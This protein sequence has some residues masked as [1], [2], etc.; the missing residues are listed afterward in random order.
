M[1]SPAKRSR[2]S[3]P[4][5]PIGPWPLQNSLS[6]PVERQAVPAR[7]LVV[8]SRPNHEVTPGE[9]SG[10]SFH[11]RR[12]ERQMKFPSMIFQQYPYIIFQ[13]K[14]GKTER[15][16]TRLDRLGLAIQWKG[17]CRARSLVGPKPQQP[18]RAPKPFCVFGIP[19]T[20]AI[21][22]LSYPLAKGHHSG[23]LSIRLSPAYPGPNRPPQVLALT[24]D[25]NGLWD[26]P[27]P[28]RSCARRYQ[29]TGRGTGFPGSDRGTFLGSTM[30]WTLVRQGS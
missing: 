4:P 24:C 17:R 2:R 21:L 23:R 18:T 12:L 26:L 25:P 13:R 15:N 8:P 28:V 29:A 20:A 19:A 14:S 30:L 5:R 6:K 1:T 7:A 9:P 16:Q 27:R 22:P 11:L 10:S 3:R